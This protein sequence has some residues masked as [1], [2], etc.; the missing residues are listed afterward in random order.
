[1]YVLC[2]KVKM[3]KR[4]A[5]IDLL[6]GLIDLFIFH[7]LSHSFLISLSSLHPR[8]HKIHL[9]PAHSLNQIHLQNSDNIFHRFLIKSTRSDELFQIIHHKTDFF[10]LLLSL[11]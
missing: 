1:M 5:I 10:L 9:S 3:E 7:R 11:N 2:T 8:L 4:K 6:I